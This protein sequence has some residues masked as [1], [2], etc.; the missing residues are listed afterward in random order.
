MKLEDSEMTATEPKNVLTL[1]RTLDAPAA[2]LWRCWTEPDLLEQWFCP[3]PWYITGARI[4]L[5]PGGEFFTVINGP[6]GERFENLGVFLAVEPEHRLVTTDAFR[7]GW[8]PGDTAF[9]TAHVTFEDAGAGRT[10]YLAQAMHWNEEN[11]KQHEQ[12][13]FHE[14]WGKAADQLED[15]A[16]TL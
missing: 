5:R 11:L 14:G 2:K 1:D 6:D 3:K 15:L 4:D 16:K 9:M 8:I 10:R 13:G 12:M 7:P